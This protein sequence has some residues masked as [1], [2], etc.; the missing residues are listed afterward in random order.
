[1]DGRKPMRLHTKVSVAAIVLLAGCGGNDKQCVAVH[2]RIATSY[3]T[4]SS[5]TSPVGVCTVGSASEN[6]AGTSRFTA[7]TSGPGP[8]PGL[9][10]YSGDLVITT[11]DGTVTLRDQG[12]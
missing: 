8:S 12:L 7:L 6:L 4:D 2:A 5:C 10:V 11:A 1:M 9:V 3:T